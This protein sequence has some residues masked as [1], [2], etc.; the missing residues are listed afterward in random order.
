VRIAAH[1]FDVIPFCGS[2]PERSHFGAITDTGKVMTRHKGIGGVAESSAAN[3]A[4]PAEEMVEPKGNDLS[5]QKTP[6]FRGSDI[7]PRPYVLQGLCNTCKPRRGVEPATAN[8]ILN[9]R[10]RWKVDRSL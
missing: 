8:L 2:A 1:F 3:A 5:A 4:L 7:G 9:G 6:I 10:N